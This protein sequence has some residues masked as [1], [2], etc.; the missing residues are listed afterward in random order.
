MKNSG[1]IILLSAVCLSFV[2]SKPKTFIP[3]GTVQITETFYA[4]ETE[5]SNISWR[6]YEYWTA[7]KF[8]AGSP[9]HIAVM[10]DT[11]VWLD[12]KAY[13][14]PYALHYYKH[15]AYKDYPVV[16]ITYNQAVA[17]CKWRTDRVKEFYMIR[18]KKDLPI[19]YRLPTIEEWEMLSHSGMTV[20]SNK[21]RDEKGRITSNHARPDDTLD[22]SAYSGTD[23]TAPVYSYRANSF[24]LY[25]SIGNVAEMVKEEG[26]SK[27]GSWRHRLDDCRVGKN[28]PYSKPESWLG[29]R[30]VCVKKRFPPN[31]NL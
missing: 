6:E 5:I 21:G 20:F 26:I 11:T 22:V 24:G 4:D 3:P 17:F 7:G 10:P 18:H 9:E 8:G 16:G 12:K 19:E 30:C 1:V 13:N 27:G 15:V 31:K 14:M 25:N 29:F 28:I 23:V 2:F